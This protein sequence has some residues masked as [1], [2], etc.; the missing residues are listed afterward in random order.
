MDGN[1][2]LSLTEYEIEKLKE[3]A[4]TDILTTME[5]YSTEDET[6]E[7][8]INVC[9]LVVKIVEAIERYKD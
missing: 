7:E 9:K 8:V 2:Y 5:V 1:Y 6:I 3:L 4:V